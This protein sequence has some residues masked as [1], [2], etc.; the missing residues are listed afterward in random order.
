MKRWVVAALGILNVVLLY[1][2][3][4]Q[5]MAMRSAALSLETLFSRVLLK[6]AGASWRYTATSVGRCADDLT[7]KYCVPV[8][9]TGFK[10]VG[11][12]QYEATYSMRAT[13]GHCEGVRREIAAAQVQP[14]LVASLRTTEELDVAHLARTSKAPV[15]SHLTFA[16]A[17]DDT[18]N[19]NDAQHFLFG[20]NLKLVRDIKIDCS[21]G[22]ISVVLA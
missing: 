22:T 6:E 3:G 8:S 18:F 15:A 5:D 1:G 19:P 21:H 20:R 4:D 13:Q 7:P 10:K 16:R 12:S 17:L 11:W 9:M 14:N 2:C